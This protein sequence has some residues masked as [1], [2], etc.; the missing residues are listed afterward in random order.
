MR[1]TLPFVYPCTRS[2]AAHGTGALSLVGAV[3]LVACSGSVTSS[4]GDGGTDGTTPPLEGGA[5]S[6][7]DGSS[8][9]PGSPGADS[10]LG[11]SSQATPDGGSTTDGAGGGEGGGASE[12]GGGG[13]AAATVCDNFDEDTPGTAP[14]NWSLV[15]G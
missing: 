10:S 4:S 7:P 2:F 5:Q 14:A 9:A 3:F 15:L 11:D 1:S 8:D 6:N 13:C 12:G